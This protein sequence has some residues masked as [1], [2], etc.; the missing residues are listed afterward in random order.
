MILLAFALGFGIY[1]SR[2]LTGRPRK[3]VQKGNIFVSGSGEIMINLSCK[4]EPKDIRVHFCDEFKTH[5]CHPCNPYQDRFDWDLV[6]TE[7]GCYRLLLTYSVANI[8][9]ISYRIKY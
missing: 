7:L 3:F 6:K 2:L 9:E 8:R 5:P 1:L 4:K